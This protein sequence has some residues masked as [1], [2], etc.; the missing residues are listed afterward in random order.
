MLISN[1]IRKVVELSRGD[2]LKNL[3]QLREK[4]K[5]SQQKLIEELNL[6]L[7]QSQIQNYETG[8]YQPDI[9]TMIKMA[10]YFGTSVDYLIGRVSY[11][12][13]SDIASDN[14]LTKTE[15]DLMDRYRRLINKKRKALFAV[16]EALEG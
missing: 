14:V 11:G 13:K 16:L 9:Q 7:S 8:K 12:R 5:L 3:R 2:E 1:F 4:S 15:Q 6:S 10:E